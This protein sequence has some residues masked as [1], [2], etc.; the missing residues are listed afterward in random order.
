MNINL[1]EKLRKLRKEKGNTQE[2]LARYLNIS[3]QS[4]SKWEC[5]DGHPDI[6]LLPSIAAYYSVTIDTLFGISEIEK[7]KRIEEI[8]NKYFKIRINKLPD[9][10]SVKM[11]RIDE[12]IELIRNALQEF[13]NNYYFMQLLA[14][15]LAFK[16]N[17]CDPE[18]K[19]KLQNEAE[20]LCDNIMKNCTESVIRDSASLILCNIYNDSG[21]YEKALEN[22]Y[23]SPDYCHTRSWKLAHIYQGEKLIKQLQN[24]IKDLTT[25]LYL[26]VTR[27]QENGGNFVFVKDKEFVIKFD[28]INKAFEG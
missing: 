13:P 4:V 26:T 8:A 19:L 10:T 23:Q 27:L 11:H 2:E 21:R 7:N 20:E 17:S 24:N 9:G 25:Y 12:G 14:S 22:A 16:A 5:G 6:T 28:A 18:L 3:V 15:D 1:G